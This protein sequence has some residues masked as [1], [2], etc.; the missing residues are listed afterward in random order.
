[1]RRRGSA[2]L[3]FFHEE[4]EGHHGSEDFFMKTVV[5]RA[6]EKRLRQDAQKSLVNTGCD[7]VR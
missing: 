1:M 5:L 6:R 4:D 2:G 7:L 3:Y